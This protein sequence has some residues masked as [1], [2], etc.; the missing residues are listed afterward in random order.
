[1]SMGIINR[2]TS[3]IKNKTLSPKKK[4]A[5]SDK[6]ILEVFEDSQSYIEKICEKIVGALR[7][8]EE[9]KI[10]YEIVT[11]YL[12]DIQKID[13]MLPEDRDKL[14]EYGHEIDKLTKERKDFQE[15]VRK[16]TNIQYRIFLENEEQMP[17]IIAKL[18]E[19]EEHLTLLK[20]D[21]EH[22]EG[23]KGSLNYEKESIYSK[24]KYINWLA[25]ITFIWIVVILG[26][27]LFIQESRNVD[28]QMPVLVVITVATAFILYIIISIYRSRRKMAVLIPKIKKAIRLLNI[29]KINYVNVKN[30]LDNTCRKYRVHNSMELEYNWSLYLEERE[31]ERKYRQTSGQLDYYASELVEILDRNRVVDSDIWIHQAIALVDDKEMVEVRH[32]LYSRRQQI[33]NEIDNH[34]EVVGAKVEELQDYVKLNP[35]IGGEVSEYLKRVG[36]DL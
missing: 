27:L 6:D 25:K 23:E 3:F 2:F 31:K 32:S 34:E 5:S 13:M 24:H 7:A 4:M 8:K 10:E 19:D 21:M 29:A 15:H 1:M 26:L 35:E 12:S 16:L 11:S 30:T 20:R 22:L 14:R 9:L 18:K 36:M 28:I 33:R 17:D